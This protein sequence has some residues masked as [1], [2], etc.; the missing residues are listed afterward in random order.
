MVPQLPDLLYAPRLPHAV[1]RVCLLLP[2]GTLW[3]AQVPSVATWLECQVAAFLESPRL[4]PLTRVEDI[5]RRPLYLGGVE[6]DPLG[7][8][9]SMGPDEKVCIVG[10]GWPECWRPVPILLTMGSSLSNFVFTIV[11]CPTLT[12]FEPPSARGCSVASTR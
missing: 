8:V 12:I 4:I 3:R 11:F 9:G 7:V 5:P 2:D 10:C 6:L 1:R